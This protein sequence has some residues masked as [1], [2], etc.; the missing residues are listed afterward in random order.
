M[1]VA[2]V[3]ASQKCVALVGARNILGRFSWGIAKVRRFSWGHFCGVGRFSWGPWNGRFSWGPTIFF[4]FSWGRLHPEECATERV[5][6][7][8][9]E[10]GE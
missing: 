8:Q 5:R 3:G 4:R 6:V 7:H 9:L 2:L 10:G 1:S